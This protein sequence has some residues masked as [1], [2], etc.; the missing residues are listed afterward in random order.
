MANNSL[1]EAYES[2]PKIVKIVLQLIL[3]GVIGGI[4]RIVRF[5]ENKN[6]VTLVVGL[7][8][9]CTGVGNAVAWIVDLV[10][11]ITSNRITVL[12]D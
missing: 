11:E 4:Y 7:L 1:T 8:T 5:V 6:V 9:L 2:L 12:A 10:T 3:G